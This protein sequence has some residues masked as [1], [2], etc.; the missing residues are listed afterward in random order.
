MDNKEQKKCI[1]CQTTM[2]IGFKI[3]HGKSGFWHLLWFRGPAVGRLQGGI[4]LKGLEKYEVVTYGC[5][6]CGY[7][8]DFVDFDS[9][10]QL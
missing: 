1:H 9:K 4:K 7:L 6:S 2:E 10:R 8:A 3:D 5:P